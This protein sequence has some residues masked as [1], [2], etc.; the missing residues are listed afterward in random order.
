MEIWFLRHGETDWNRECR[1]Q[2]STA[3][4]DLTPFGV[5]LAEL[6]RDG[7]LSAGISFDCAFTSPYRRAVHTAEIVA[8][9]LG[10]AAEPDDRL[11]EMSFGEYEG[12]IHGEGKYVDANIRACFEDP[13]S[14]VAGKG[15]ESFE[16]LRARA[17]AFISGLAPLKAHGVRRAL[18][19]THG[20]FMRAVVSVAAKTPIA[21]FWRGSQ[22]NCC[23]HVVSVD[24]DGRISLAARAR[25]FYPDKL[26]SKTLS[27]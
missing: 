27:V 7:L 19:V 3:H 24:G 22:P 21:D 6:T 23:V 15:A 5:Q 18:A 4:T 11:R 25:T 1:I 16:E 20:T 9:G 13:A 17:E 8:G 12:T 10:M 14:Y 2:G 26:L